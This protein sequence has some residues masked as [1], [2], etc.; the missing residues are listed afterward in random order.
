MGKSATFSGTIPPLKND[1]T[2]PEDESTLYGYS[3]TPIMYRD[4]YIDANN[5][6]GSY[7]VLTYT[8]GD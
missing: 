5:Q 7:Y 8:A 4:H 3:F 6:S 2:T 1:P